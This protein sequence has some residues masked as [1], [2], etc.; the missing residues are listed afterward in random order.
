MAVV[1]L[2]AGCGGSGGKGGSQGGAATTGGAAAGEKTTAQGGG[3]AGQPAQA[4]VVTLKVADSFP[5]A[6]WAP[7]EAVKPWMDRATQLS[8]GKIKFEYYPSEQLG[9]LADMLNL[10][11]SGVTDIAYLAPSSLAGDLPLSSVA[12]LPGAFTTS[13]EGS[14]AYAALLKEGP[15]RQ[16]F[17][18]HGVRPL[19]SFVL[20]SYEIFSTKAPLAK[21][22]NLKGLK[23]RTSGGSQDLVVKA[24][25]G[26]PVTIPTPE[27][28]T[29][30]QRGTADAAVFPYASIKDY[31]LDE[32]VKHGTQGAGITSYAVVYAINQKVWERL[33]RDIQDA[34]QR[35]ADEV[36]PKAIAYQD[37]VTAKLAEEFK[38]KGITIYVLSDQ[39]KAR[40][41]QATAP[42]WDQWVKDMEAKGLPGRQVREAFEKALGR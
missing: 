3:S 39:E 17:E 38:A 21:M 34:L 28:Y 18:K 27:V 20:P 35:A 30:L 9:K 42:V 26:V 19:W 25:G 22:E 32:L 33:P 29:A 7:R 14:A 6:H 31:K 36:I 11:K 24:L 12:F 37:D 13:A 1:L 41:R 8:N 40:W 2:A 16:D 4:E 23:I 10:L 5:P 15:A